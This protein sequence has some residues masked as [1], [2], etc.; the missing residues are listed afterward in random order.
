M[1]APIGRGDCCPGATALA[2]TLAAAIA[3]G[4]SIARVAVHKLKLLDHQA[5]LAAVLAVLFPPVAF[6]LTF[7]TPPP[8]VLPA[9][10]DGKSEFTDG[11]VIRQRPQ[12]R[13][14]GKA[15]IRMTLLKVAMIILLVLMATTL[16]GVTRQPLPRPPQRERRGGFRE[17]S[18]S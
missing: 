3:N 10:I 11:G 14:T 15:T 7:R 18:L 16:G 9:A 4:L 6:E 13:I 1:P 5:N 12:N 2:I 17:R 8:L